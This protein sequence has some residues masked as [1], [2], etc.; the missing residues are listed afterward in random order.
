MQIIKIIKIIVTILLM[1]ITTIIIQKL[2]TIINSKDKLLI[3]N[4]RILKNIAYNNK[5]ATTITC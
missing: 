5:I 3:I 4:L 1:I 2:V